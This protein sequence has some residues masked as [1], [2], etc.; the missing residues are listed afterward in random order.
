MVH[1]VIWEGGLEG[2]SRTEIFVAS[3]GAVGHAIAEAAG[4]YALLVV[5]ALELAG[6]TDPRRTADLV[7]PVGA[8]GHPIAEVQSRDAPTNILCLPVVNLL[9]IPSSAF[10]L[11]PSTVAHTRLVIVGQLEP[12]STGT[13]RPDT[14]CP[15]EAQ[16]ATA[17]LGADILS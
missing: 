2:P 6:E 13:L 1:E 15:Q 7:L 5:V 8:V 10:D 16:L 9:W 12:V 14:S 4:G 11:R 17:H 3:V